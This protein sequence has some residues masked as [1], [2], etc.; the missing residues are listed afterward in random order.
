MS[1]Q[2]NSVEWKIPSQL[3]FSCKMKLIVTLQGNVV[4]NV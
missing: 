4:D 3:M 2:V 1:I